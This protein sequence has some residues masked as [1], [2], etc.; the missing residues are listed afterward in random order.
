MIL[1][2]SKEGDGIG[3]NMYRGGGLL[4]GLLLESQPLAYMHGSVVQRH[5]RSH[6][7]GEMRL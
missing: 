1:G 7:G 2:E 5:R 6:G 3:S 4:L